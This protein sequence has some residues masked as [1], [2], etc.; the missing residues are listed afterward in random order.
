MAQALLNNMMAQNPNVRGAYN[1]LMNGGANNPAVRQWM[2]DATRVGP[3]QAF[4]DSY[5]QNPDFRKLVDDA[6]AGRL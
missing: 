3:E 5:N 1:M 4:N 2:D 6:R